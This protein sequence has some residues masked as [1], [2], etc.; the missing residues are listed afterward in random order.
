MN[1][2]TSISPSQQDSIAVERDE[3][4]GLVLD[5]L[6]KEIVPE[7]KVLQGEESL[8]N[9]AITN[10]IKKS[11]TELCRNLEWLTT[12]SPKQ[13]FCWGI[14]ASCCCKVPVRKDSLEWVQDYDYLINQLCHIYKVYC[15]GQGM[16]AEEDRRLKEELP[17][18]LLHDDDIKTLVYL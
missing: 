1:C 15:T 6:K 10:I 18:E 4:Q 3:F 7:F 9:A 12:V 2:D 8:S 11:V 17:K 13:G 5:V 14:V 16:R